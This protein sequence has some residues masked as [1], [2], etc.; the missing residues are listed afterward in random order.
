MAERGVQSF[1][2]QTSA[3]CTH[4]FPAGQVKAV[5]RRRGCGERRA[6]RSLAAHDVRGN[7]GFRRLYMFVNARQA[8]LPKGL[9]PQELSMITRVSPEY[10]GIA[11]DR[12]AGWTQ[13]VSDA[14]VVGRER[15]RRPQFCV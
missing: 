12:T 10:F 15:Q 8:Y 4:H 1:L 11:F 6:F 3:Y 7:H 5:T 13:R 14:F 9:I 2:T